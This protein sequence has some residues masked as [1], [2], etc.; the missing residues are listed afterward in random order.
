M[1]GAECYESG[2]SLCPQQLSNMT[3]PVGPDSYTC[4]CAAGWAGENCGD[5]IDECSSNPCLFNSTC[6]NSIDGGDGG[7]TCNC[8]VV[9]FSGDNCA[10]DID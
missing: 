10:D 5:D 7:Y 3:W 9:G 6:I 8:T 2:S 4:V 1:N